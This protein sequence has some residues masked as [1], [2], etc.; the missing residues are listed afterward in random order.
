L[1]FEVKYDSHV[2]N[3]PLL[4]CGEFDVDLE[5]LDARMVVE[6]FHVLQPFFSFCV[7]LLN[8]PQHIGFHLGP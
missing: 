7:T 2:S 5:I 6:A 1:K 8:G 3:V 4:I